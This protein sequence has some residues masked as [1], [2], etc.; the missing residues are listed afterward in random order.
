[1]P[2]E[3]HPF[4]ALLD[5]GQPVGR[6]IQGLLTEAGNVLLFNAIRNGGTFST[7]NIAKERYFVQHCL[8]SQTRFKR[9]GRAPFSY[10]SMKVDLAGFEDWLWLQ[11]ISVE[12]RRNRLV[13]NYKAPKDYR[14]NLPFGILSIEHDLSG[15][16]FGISRRNNVKIVESA[17]IKITRSRG[18]SLKEVQDY[19]RNLEDLIIILT[20]SNYNLDWPVL[21]P[22]DSKHPAKLYFQR[23]RSGD[24]PP[25]AHDCLV[26][27]PRIAE[28]F[29]ELFA[30]FTEKR[31]RYGPGIYLYL[32]TRRGVKMFVEHR[33]VNLIWGL[34]AFDRRG[35]GQVQVGTA[36]DEKIRRI[37]AQVSLPKDRAWLE[38]KLK[39]AAEPNLS[40]RL[41]SIFSELPLPFDHDELKNFCEECQARRNDIS[42]FGGLR[43]PDQPYDEFM[44]DLDR[45]SNALSALYHL[46]LLT[47]IGVDKER[48]DFAKNQNRPMWRMEYD[49]RIVGLLMPKQGPQG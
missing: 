8:V 1:M 4:T 12:R 19:H 20:A 48:L 24:S 35:R 22:W 40:Q 28:S 3:E 36:L 15:P 17:A 14:F 34:E 42:H 39:N 10:R 18:M 44:Q 37:I 25:G 16:Y 32:G 7:N 11:S 5:N 38:N 41:L 26:N 46:H 49:L 2:S 29:G 6:N 9:D 30:A 27:F 33:F 13:A 23:Y 21:Y 45:K 43:H 31:E 47:I